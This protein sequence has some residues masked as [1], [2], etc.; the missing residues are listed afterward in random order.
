[1][2]NPSAP[3]NCNRRFIFVFAD[4]VEIRGQ[5]YRGR[6]ETTARFEQ[7]QPCQQFLVGP[8]RGGVSTGFVSGQERLNE[9]LVGRNARETV[10]CKRYTANN[11]AFFSSAPIS[12]P[13]SRLCKRLVTLQ[14]RRCSRRTRGPFEKRA[15]GVVS[16]KWGRVLC[17]RM[18]NLHYPAG[19]VPLRRGE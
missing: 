8:R 1:M 19:A 14:L 3:A 6:R 9:N 10:R 11:D 5:L 13:P 12:P 7:V 15:R 2:F 4:S 18:K 17:D 16:G